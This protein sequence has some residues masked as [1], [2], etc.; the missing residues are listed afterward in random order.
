MAHGDLTVRSK[1]LKLD[2]L[3]DSKWTLCEM[4]TL[5]NVHFHPF[6]PD[7]QYVKTDSSYLYT[8]CL[9]F[10]CHETRGSWVK[11]CYQGQFC[12]AKTIKLASISV[13]GQNQVIIHYI[14]R[15]LAHFTT[16]HEFQRLP[17]CKS[18]QL[19]FQSSQ[20]KP[21]NDINYLYCFG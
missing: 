15:S 9:V 10:K 21:H 2:D 13:H 18:W 14:D 6:G 5:W 7:S 17:G 4:T 16:F 12:S 19:W 1:R 20:F 8:K 11:I 3:K